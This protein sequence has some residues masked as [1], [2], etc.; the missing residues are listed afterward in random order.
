MELPAEPIE[1]ESGPTLL[2][3]TCTVLFA[4]TW[5]DA[6]G[7]SVS[8]ALAAM[9]GLASPLAVG[10]M[11]G[12]MQAGLVM[13][14][15][16]LAMSNG[17][18]GQTFR[19]QVP[20]LIYTMLAGSLA[21][22]A[23]SIISGQGLPTIVAI[24]A[25]AALAGLVGGISRPLVRASTLFI[26]YTIIATNLGFQA[27]HPLAMMILFSLGSLWTAVLFLALRP[28][29][30]AMSPNSGGKTA[31]P[32]KY[33]ARLL[34]RRWWKSLAHLSGWQYVLRLTL[35]LVAAEAYELL[36]PG[37]HGYWVAITVTIVVQRNLQTALART[38][39]RGAGTVLGVLLTSLLLMGSPSMWTLIAMIAAL[40]AARPILLEANYTAYAA[41][42]TPLVILLLD[43]GRETSWVVVTDRLLAT[44][45]GCLMALVLGYFLWFRLSSPAPGSLAN[46]GHG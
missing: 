9:L 24:P 3:R 44:S 11:A 14:L 27:G 36:W 6:G 41:V 20:G 26:L 40:A 4:G 18:Q 21:M 23:G 29:F 37:H 32:R 5:S 43:F 38:F 13:S 2:K 1:M 8:R 34:L 15:G 10:A 39:H 35:C 22:L 45:A 25:L 16:G 33:P 30:K 31:P 28:L 17:G 12:Q 7:H 42:M 19:E 46:K